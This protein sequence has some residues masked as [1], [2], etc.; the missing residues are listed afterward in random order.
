MVAIPLS[1]HTSHHCPPILLPSFPPQHIDSPVSPNSL[2]PSY[3]LPTLL[4]A[5]SFLSPLP[6]CLYHFL[7][8]GSLAA[9][10]LSMFS[11]SSFSFH[12]VKPLEFCFRLSIAFSGW[13]ALLKAEVS[14]IVLCIVGYINISCFFFPPAQLQLQLRNYHP[15]P[16]VLTSPFTHHLAVF[17]TWH[18]PLHSVITPLEPTF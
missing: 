2:I 5:G 8:I 11:H 6:S 1:C 14:V 18:S 3:L 9:L 10:S 16:S 15:W 12:L 17:F 7:L 13:F 4:F